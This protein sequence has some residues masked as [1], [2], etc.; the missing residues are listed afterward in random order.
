MLGIAFAEILGALD[1]LF[2]QFTQ[3]DVALILPRP[4][5]VHFQLEGVHLVADGSDVLR[6]QVPLVAAL[7]EIAGARL[8]LGNFRAQFRN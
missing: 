4:H 1:N 8:K 7:R 6:Q 3:Q 5:R 2:P